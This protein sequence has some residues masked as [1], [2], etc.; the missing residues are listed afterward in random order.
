MFY[1]RVYFSE[2][3]FAMELD[4]SHLLKNYGEEE[5]TG[6]NDKESYINHHLNLLRQDFQGPLSVTLQKLMSGSDCGDKAINIGRGHLVERVCHR[7]GVLYKFDMSEVNMEAIQGSLLILFSSPSPIL[8]VVIEQVGKQLLLEMEG[9]PPPSADPDYVIFSFSVHFEAYRLSLL[10]LASKKCLPLQHCILENKVKSSKLFKEDRI[11][12]SCFH[13]NFQTIKK[14]DVWNT[15]DLYR[16]LMNKEDVHCISNNSLQNI[17]EPESWRLRDVEG[18]QIEALRIALSNDLGLIHGPPGTGKTSV[19]V[20]IIRLILQNRGRLQKQ[21]DSLPVLV[22]CA[23]NRGLDQLLEQLLGV[24]LRLVRLG[25]RS[26][27][28]ALQ[29]HNLGK[30]KEYTK[31][32]QLRRKDRY[33]T[34]KQL[35]AELRGLEKEVQRILPEDSLPKDL[36]DQIKNVTDQLEQLQRTE[37]AS[38]LRR[39]EIVGMTV[40]RAAREWKLLELLAPGIVVV[41]EAAEVLESHLVAALPLSAKHLVL[42]G[43]HLQLRPIL[44]NASMQRKH[45]EANISL[46]ERLMEAGNGVRLS[47]QH[48]MAPD[49]ANVLTPLY[50]GLEN[51]PSVMKIPQLPGMGG[52]LHCITHT[53]PPVQGAAGSWKNVWEAE[54]VVGLLRLLEGFGVRKVDMVVLSPYASQVRLLTD[55]TSGIDV[56]TVDSFQ[57]QERDIVVM[58]L[59]RSGNT[60][61]GFL[62]SDNRASVALSRARRGLLLVGDLPLLA[63]HSVLWNQCYS[64]LQ[65]QKRVGP[66]LKMTCDK[67]GS[68]T[69]IRCPEDFLM[70]LC[71][72]P[73]LTQLLCSHLCSLQCHPSLPHACNSSCQRSCLRE[74]PCTSSH[75]CPS[76]CPPCAEPVIHSLPCGHTLPGPCHLREL[77]CLAVMPTRLVCGHTVDTRCGR[78]ALCTECNIQ[79]RKHNIVEEP[80]K[81]KGKA[82]KLIETATAKKKAGVNQTLKDEIIQICKKTDDPCKMLKSFFLNIVHED[83]YKKEIL[84]VTSVTALACLMNE[85]SE[86]NKK[87][88]KVK[89]KMSGFSRSLKPLADGGPEEQLIL[90]NA[91]Q[92]SLIMEKLQRGSLLRWFMTLYDEEVVQ[93]E[94]FLKWKEEVDPLYEGKGEALIQVNKWL[95]WLEQADEESEED[96][97]G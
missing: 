70:P 96:D 48:R 86:V 94:V 40:T 19:A 8:G 67:H 79:Y 16:A 92:E 34:Q 2:Y 63:S 82:K 17:F 28:K 88:E 13:K 76:P 25:T 1:Y 4:V 51:H 38:L 49:L 3:H 89:E 85:P 78:P 73:C 9:V 23:T 66:E 30:L 57:G 95:T 46:F 26:E 54:M 6:W 43:D 53:Y 15:A 58:S 44:A 32:E 90:L 41:E 35:S 55:L 69:T 27:S 39:A 5:L 11:D 33:E 12:L 18:S 24:S 36:L 74:H 14:E 65:Q 80:T 64:I 52:Y 42:L 97:E 29:A 68:V 56:T 21:S 83:K 45:P 47:T 59:V 60:G 10:S 62:S 93:E 61:V 22:L 81:G 75:P 84:L 72:S 71:T 7:Q 20:Q 87:K 31:E 37:D 91:L 50:P 77:I